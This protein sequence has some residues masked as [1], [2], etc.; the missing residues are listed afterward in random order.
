ME[1]QE[2][3]SQLHT[4]IKDVIPTSPEISFPRPA[5]VNRFNR[6][7][8]GVGLFLSETYKWGMASMAACKCR[9]KEQTAEHVI[10]SCFIYHHPNIARALSDVDKNLVTWLMKTFP[11][12]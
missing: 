10:T 3:A 6:L 11:A 4:F 9:A 2:N 1:W 7:R 8:T 5:W 12:I